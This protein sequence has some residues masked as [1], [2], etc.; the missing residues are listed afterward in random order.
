MKISV[1]MG[2]FVGVAGF[3]PTT[4]WSQTRRDDQTTLHPVL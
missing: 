2:S 3:E 4:S 1:F